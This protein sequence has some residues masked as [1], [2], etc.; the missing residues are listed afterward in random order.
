MADCAYDSGLL[1]VMQLV[2]YR[3]TNA[4]LNHATASVSEQI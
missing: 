4:S 3:E 2:V 1:Q